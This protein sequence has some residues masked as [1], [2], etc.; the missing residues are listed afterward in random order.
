TDLAFSKDSKLLAT[1]AADGPARLWKADRWDAPAYTSPVAAT[2]GPRSSVW[3]VEFGP[4]GDRWL[5]A[6]SD[7]S[8]VIRD[9][10][11]RVKARSHFSHGA[12]FLNSLAGASFDADGVHV[13]I[14]TANDRLVRWDHSTGRCSEL[15]TGKY[16][17]GARVP[18]RELVWTLTPEHH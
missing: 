14:D 10:T 15:Q 9:L 8:V 11:G 6:S 3:S 18:G 16:L 1:A 4:T 17:E 12:C 5:A 13:L 2:S 7:G